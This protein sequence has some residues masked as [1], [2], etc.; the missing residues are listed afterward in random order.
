M[1]EDIKI[2]VIIPV[3]NVEQ[4]I[5]ECV[6][7][8]LNQTYKNLEVILVDDGSPD[9]CPQICDKYANEDDRVKV[10][11]KKNGGLSSARNAGMKVMSGDYV[12]F[13][14]SDDFWNDKNFICDVIQTKIKDKFPDITIFGYAMYNQ[15]TKE[16]KNYLDFS[17]PFSGDDK[18][19]QV[20]SLIDNNMYQSS[21]CN[22]IMKIKLFR[23]NDL[24]FNEGVFSE[25]I[26]FSA[27]LLI[28]AESF[29]V[30]EKTIYMYRQN[31]DSITHKIKE[32]N[33]L[34][35]CDNIKK[36]IAFSQAIKDMPYYD[37]YM[38]Y[39]AYQYITFL[40]IITKVNKEKFMPKYK[41][42]M[43][44]YCWLLKYDVNS[45]VKM[46]NKFYKL[47]GYSGMLKIL[48]VYLKLRG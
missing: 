24:T 43:K 18:A 20:K 28:C 48:A 4:Y 44:E 2:S 1:S 32:K 12:I 22:K 10:V 40:N 27:R 45:K 39:C 42:D 7:S 13:L 36:I 19:Q 30:Y 23:D 15:D 8:V 38:N 6:N 14:D 31:T 41:Q 33:V 11:H 17:V 26:D 3:Y 46:I 16:T 5:S 29:A 21:S 25:D 37:S 35:L 9:S 34:D 47:F